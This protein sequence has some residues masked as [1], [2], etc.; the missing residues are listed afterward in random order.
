MSWRV[1]VV[2]LGL[3]SAVFGA[4][5]PRALV[6][7]DGDGPGTTPGAHFDTPAPAPR[8]GE[9]APDFELPTFDGTKVLRLSTFRGAR[10][11]VLVFGSYT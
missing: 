1:A 8:A 5:P 4:P 10:P 7:V 9:Y 3:V 2:L 11:V 6:P